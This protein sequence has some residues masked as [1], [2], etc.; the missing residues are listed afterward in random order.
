MAASEA[1][2]SCVGSMERAG[3]LADVLGLCIAQADM[4]ITLGSLRGAM[5]TY[6]Q[7]LRIAPDHG[8]PVLRGTADMY[9]GMS[10]LH[11]E[12]NDLGAARQLLAQSEELGEHL[13]LRQNP[14]RWRVAMSR[15]LEAEGDLDEVVD[16]LDAA[17]R[18]YV[19]D[20]SPNVRP[21][22]AVRARA[23]IRQGRLDDAFQWVH[24]QGLSAEDELELPPR[25]RARDAGKSAPGRHARARRALPR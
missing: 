22:P 17:E 3:N 8:V 21:V 6:E 16:L 25:V 12:R 2:A 23:W 4:Q 1:Y 10:A 11:R 13:A 19:G 14:Y 24:D 7:G 9:V 18:V 20:F 5:R 15:L